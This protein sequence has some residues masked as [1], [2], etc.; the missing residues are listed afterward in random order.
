MVH[1]VPTPDDLAELESLARLARALAI[2]TAWDGSP[3][4]HAMA[5][6][7]VIGLATLAAGPRLAA[8]STRTETRS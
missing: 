1:S 4:V 7:P 6:A 3:G 8:Q 5:R 2:A